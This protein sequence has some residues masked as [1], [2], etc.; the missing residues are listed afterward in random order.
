MQAAA[1]RRFKITA[2]APL[3][4]PVSLEISVTPW[5]NSVFFCAKTPVI[6]T[7]FLI[8][9]QSPNR[10]SEGASR[11]YRIKK[12]KSI[13]VKPV[14]PATPP[15]RPSFG[16]VD[17]N[18]QRA[19]HL[20]KRAVQ[21]EKDMT[22]GDRRVLHEEAAILRLSTSGAKE[23][24]DMFMTVDNLKDRH[25]HRLFTEKVIAEYEQKVIAKQHPAR[26]EEEAAGDGSQKAMEYG[27]QR[28]AWRAEIASRPPRVGAYGRLSFDNVGRRL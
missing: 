14:D 4:A 21:Y 5:S 18:I 13:Y 19:D 10:Q 12:K 23:Y 3:V 20:L 17:I 27:A 11:R 22:P 28:A 26:T 8:N 1:R 16:K 25:D 7:R 15:R 6:P 24:L 9:A 2:A